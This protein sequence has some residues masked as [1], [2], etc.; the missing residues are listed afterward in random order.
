MPDRNRVRVES[1]QRIDKPDFEALQLGAHLAVRYALRGLLFGTDAPA[2]VAVVSSWTLTAAGSQLS[3][4]PGR[5]VAGE[6]MPDGT[7]Q[8]GHV[9]GEDGDA[10]Q[11]LDFVGEPAATYGIYVRADF[12]PGVSGSRIF[13]NA[14]TEVEDAAAID[15]REVSGWNAVA[16]ATALGDGYV[17]IGTVVWNGAAFTSVTRADAP[18]LLEGTLDSSGVEAVAAWGDGANDRDVDR[19]SYGVQ[20]LVRAFGLIRRQLKDIVGAASG[21]WGS[22]VPTSLTAAKAHIDT[23]TDPHGSAPT[24]T[25]TPVFNGGIDVNDPSDFSDEVTFH[26]NIELAGT[27]LGQLPRLVDSGYAADDGRL[28]IRTFLPADFTPLDGPWSAG[29]WATPTYL[30][31]LQGSGGSALTLLSLSSRY[32]DAALGTTAGPYI[33]A[34]VLYGTDEAAG[35]TGGTITGIL[36]ARGV[37][38]AAWTNLV[39]FNINNGDFGSTGSPAPLSIDLSTVSDNDRCMGLNTQYQLYLAFNDTTTGSSAKLYSCAV[40]T[41]HKFL[42]P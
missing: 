28:S 4:V 18:H 11:T 26:D 35:G 37:T 2:S 39:T 23:T 12:S 5:S 7:V 34:I 15:T 40:Y 20:S 19:A 21:H 36:Q 10:S 31:Y 22:A 33:Y 16:S 42:S 9:L 1:N 41:H 8:D 14:A 17:R 6:V 25:G 30:R 32:A 24:W 3:I 38:D 27:G 13:W 29:D